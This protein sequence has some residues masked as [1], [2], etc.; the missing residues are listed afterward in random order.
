M[1]ENGSEPVLWRP[2]EIADANPSDWP[3]QTPEEELVGCYG[4]VNT[5]L[6]TIDLPYPHKL[7]WKKTATVSRFSCHRRV[8]DSLLR[9]LTG[10]LD[11]YGM[12]EIQRLRLDLWGGC[13]NVR[14]MRGGSRF[15]MHSWGIAVDYDPE[16]NK[17]KW[18]R[19]RASF[20][21]SAYDR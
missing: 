3:D 7:S 14:R 5:N 11:H 9:V 21:Q 13:L 1:L 4:E 12:D 17:L 8:H 16:K 6:T 2:E 15:S 10:V 20:A 19:D 18:G